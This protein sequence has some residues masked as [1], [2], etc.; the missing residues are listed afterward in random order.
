MESDKI[1]EEIDSADV[2]TKATYMIDARCLIEE[3]AFDFVVYTPRCNKQKLARYIIE[4]YWIEAFEAYGPTAENI[5]E[6]IINLWNTPYYDEN[7]GEEHTFREWTMIF[8]KKR[9]RGE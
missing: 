7:S 8:F 1:Y 3:K 9:M 4:E 6:S 2:S 5:C